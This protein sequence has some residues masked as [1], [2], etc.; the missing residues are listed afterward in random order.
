MSDPTRISHRDIIEGLLRPLTPETSLDPRGGVLR[1]CHLCGNDYADREAVCVDAL[2]PEAW[3]GKTVCRSCVE[4]R[5]FT[6]AAFVTRPS[7]AGFEAYVFGRDEPPEGW[8]F[9]PPTWLDLSTAMV[10][11]SQ[12][13]R[14]IARSATGV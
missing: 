6:G 1:L 9:P 8:E 7:W 4:E 14:P 5:E 3:R 13:W 11:G 10:R 2:Y 12:T